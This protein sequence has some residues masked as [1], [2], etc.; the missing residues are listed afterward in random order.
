MFLFITASIFMFISKLHF[1]KKVSIVTIFKLNSNNH[2][3]KNDA[4]NINRI[5]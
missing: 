5:N 3:I 4:I 1:P 2:N